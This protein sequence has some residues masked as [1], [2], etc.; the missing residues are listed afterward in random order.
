MSEPVKTAVIY[1][2]ATGNVHK[3]AT[4]LAEGA[5]KAG[6]DVRLRKVAELAPPQAIASNPQWAEHVESSR[7]VAEAGMDD[8]LWADVVLLGTPTRYGAMAS[9]LKQFIDT[10]GP[11][12]Q[13][14]L[15]ADKVYGA[16]GSAGTRHGGS[17]QFQAGTPYGT[18]HVGGDGVPGD[19]A[20]ESGRYQ[21]RRAV[22]TAAKL[23]A[24]RT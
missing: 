20:L 11:A 8:L 21:A 24:G 9:Q 14:G 12:W 3:L 19:L 7:D 2:S 18:T 4:A 17:I 23:K 1:Y 16:F 10:T 5:E 6:S 22:E 15:L 13:K